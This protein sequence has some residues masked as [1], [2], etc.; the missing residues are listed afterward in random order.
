M[1]VFSIV[2]TVAHKAITSAALLL[3]FNSLHPGVLSGRDCCNF[4]ATGSLSGQPAHFHGKVVYKH[5]TV[6]QVFHLCHVAL[7]RCSTLC[8]CSPAAVFYLCRCRPA[9][10]G[11]GN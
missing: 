9:A 2:P 7:R 8:Y 11:G 1:V 4:S 3:S 10:A 5:A 6:P